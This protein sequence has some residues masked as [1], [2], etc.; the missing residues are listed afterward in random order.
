MSKRKN[1]KKRKGKKYRPYQAVKMKFVRMPDPFGDAP[2]EVRRKVMMEI[3]TAGKARFDAAYPKLIEWFDTYDPLYILSFC[4][5]Y[6]LSSEQGVDKE[7]VDGK[8]DFASHHLELLQAFALMRPRSGTPAP[9]KDRAMELQETLKSITEDLGLAQLTVLR[10][11]MSDIEVKK[12][13]VINL[14]GRQDR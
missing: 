12:H 1:R 3:A 14:N 10:D 6:F 2:M 11:G 8:L 4:V 7:A 5:L 9:L 13:F